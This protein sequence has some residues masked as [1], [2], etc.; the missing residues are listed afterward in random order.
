MRA[1]ARTELNDVGRKRRAVVH[2]SALLL[3]AH[4]ACLQPYYVMMRAAV[5]AAAASAMSTTTKPTVRFTGTG[6]SDV[7]APIEAVAM[8]RKRPT[9]MDI[10]DDAGVHIP[11]SCCAGTCAV[12]EVK[13]TRNGRERTVRACTATPRDEDVVD[14]SS[15]DAE[16]ARMMARFEGQDG[17]NYGRAPAAPSRPARPPPPPVYE[18]AWTEPEPVVFADDDDDFSLGGGAAPWDVIQ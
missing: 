12:C 2:C 14:V 18:D 7:S 1:I 11:R 9:L 10:A 4:D 5:F 8:G 6:G 17:L 3:R 15:G 13:I 16:L